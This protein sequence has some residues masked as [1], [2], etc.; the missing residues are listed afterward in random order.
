MH[1]SSISQVQQ[2]VPCAF[3][4][5]RRSPSMLHLSSAILGVGTDKP[6]DVVEKIQ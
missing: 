5:C 1:I 2:A 3:Q 6:S 4:H